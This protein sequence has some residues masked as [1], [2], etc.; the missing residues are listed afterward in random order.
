M[1]KENEI[2]STEESKASKDDEVEQILVAKK[3]ENFDLL[4][5]K[6]RIRKRM[7]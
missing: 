4:K 3:I 5:A 1:E 7:K 6:T 2:G